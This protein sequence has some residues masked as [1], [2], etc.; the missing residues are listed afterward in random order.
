MCSQ[1]PIDQILDLSDFVAGETRSER[2]RLYAVSAHTGSLYSGHY[3]AH[4]KNYE[5]QWFT[6]NDSYTAA[7]ELSGKSDV[8][9]TAYLLFYERVNSKE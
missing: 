8:F 4:P 2:F 1:F 3:V 7:E 5:K 6:F 9:A